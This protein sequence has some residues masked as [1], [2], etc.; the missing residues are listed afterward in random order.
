M[1][2]KKQPLIRLAIHGGA[3][4]LRREIRSA[5]KAAA[6]EKALRA[7]L[8]A[9][10]TI[11]KKDG[12]ALEAVQAAVRMLEDT[13]LFNAGRGSVLNRD[14]A[15][16]MDAAI[17]DG[18]TLRAGA[19]AGV[20]LPR[21]PID[22]A[23]AVME[24]SD[25][26]MLVGPGA[27]AFCRECGL[28][29]ELPAYFITEERV[30]EWRK[31]QKGA[32]TQRGAAAPSKPPKHGTVGAVALDRAGNLAAATSTGGML[33]KHPGRVGDSP[34]IGAGTYADNAACA[35][36]CAGYG[37]IF[38]RAVAA[39]HIAALTAAAGL[40]LVEAV[41][42]TLARIAALGGDGGVIALDPKGNLELQCNSE[43]MFRGWTDNRGALHTAV[44][45]S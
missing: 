17:M 22:A 29:L 36:S 16:E 30:R 4:A 2:S 39:H 34:L 44:F 21:N 5:E 38:I 33:N 7:A 32:P 14:G 42:R 43:G 9:G 37:E 19:V 26:V 18:R 31:L 23:R 40:P 11:L 20:T 24:R 3:G 15:V 6:C 8:R 10:Y 45:G 12:P 1:L 25:H 13:P 27:D 35:V 28:P 41:R